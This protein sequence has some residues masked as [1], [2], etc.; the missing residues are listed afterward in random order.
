MLIPTKAKCCLQDGGA[1]EAPSRPLVRVVEDEPSIITLFGSMGRL[2]GFDVA[3]YATKA[4]FLAGFDAARPG[5]LVLDQ[6][7][8]DGTGLE[9][10]EELARDE[11]PLPVLFMSGIAKVT[12]AITAFRLGSIDFVEK[13]FDLESMAEAIGRAIQ[14]D[15]ERRQDNACHDAVGRR[16]A[17]LTRREN[18]VMELVVRGASNK[19]IAAAL[20]L[21]PKTVEVHRANVMQKSEAQ[22][23]AELVRLHVALHTPARQ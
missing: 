8:P 12:E 22:S 15:A 1:P 20:G 19:E 10:I 17:R 11:C 4:E 7:L 14:L 5:C 23:V 16:F 13:P 3:A 18:E 21:S 6:N 9:I 2:N